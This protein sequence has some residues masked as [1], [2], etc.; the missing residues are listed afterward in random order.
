[1]DATLRSFT[2]EAALYISLRFLDV[3]KFPLNAFEKLNL[4]CNVLVI[5]TLVSQC[6]HLFHTSNLHTLSILS[7]LSATY[8]L[9]YLRNPIR[10]MIALTFA[11]FSLHTHSV[12]VYPLKHVANHDATKNGFRFPPLN[13]RLPR[14]TR[15]CSLLLSGDFVSIWRT[16]HRFFRYNAAGNALA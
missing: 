6:R 13:F 11:K 15:C 3:S 5:S 7:V 2:P 4:H 10:A 14:M 16:V 8:R 12:D 1:L 9:A